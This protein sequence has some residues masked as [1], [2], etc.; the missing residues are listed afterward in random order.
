M[1]LPERVSVL[2]N[3]SSWNGVARPQNLAIHTLDGG[4]GATEGA[5]DVVW[6]GCR[7]L[8]TPRSQGNIDA[9]PK[10]RWATGNACRGVRVHS[11][12]PQLT[13]RPR[14]QRIYVGE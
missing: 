7:K 11:Y 13:T 1:R 10:H 5:T 6:R 4:Q 9:I 3:R 12:V 14:V 2:F 8:F